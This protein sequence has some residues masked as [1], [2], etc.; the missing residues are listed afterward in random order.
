MHNRSNILLGAIHNQVRILR[1]LVRI[2][3]AGETLN[4]TLAGLLVDASPV[5]ALAVVERSRDVHE[6]ERSRL[7]NG[8]AGFLASLLEGGDGSGNDS[9]AGLGQLGSNESD[10]T[11]VEITI[12]AGEAQLRGQLVTDVLAQ[13]H[14]YG[15]TAA[16][17]EGDLEGTRDLVFAGV[18]VAG[19]ED[20]ETLLAGER[21]LLAKYLDDLRV[22]EPLGDLLAGLEAVTQL[23]TGNVHGLCT[24]GDLVLGPVLVLA[25]EVNHL[26]ELDHADAN[27]LL[28]LGDEVLGIVGAVVVLAVLVLAGTGVV[29][30]DDEV[31]AAVVLADN[32]VPESLT[33]TTHA[34]S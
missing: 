34:H 21:V 20:G 14:G 1:H 18:G 24:L 11:N 15:T 2:V 19:H 9:S 6:E 12:F 28:V 17:V 31:C 27:L 22:G 5:S 7:L 23:C 29:T 25:G 13:Q 3:H 30:A 32:G 26:L 4:L 33:R 16:L 10:T 8:V